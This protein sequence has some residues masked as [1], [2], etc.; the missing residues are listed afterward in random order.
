VGRKGGSD[1]RDACDEEVIQIGNEGLTMM[2]VMEQCVGASYHRH[3]D[4]SGVDWIGK[5][6]MLEEMS[7]NG[8]IRDSFIKKSGK[9]NCGRLPE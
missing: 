1:S 8:L 3:Q 7:M 9:T 5:A 4:D 6:S 2:R